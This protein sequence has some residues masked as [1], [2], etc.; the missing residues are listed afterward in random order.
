VL[1][2]GVLCYLRAR[3]Q[4]ELLPPSRI[5][6][7]EEERQY[8]LSRRQKTRPKGEVRNPNEGPAPE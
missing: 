3:Q 7:D 6:L 5:E 8:L 1:A 2:W 4:N